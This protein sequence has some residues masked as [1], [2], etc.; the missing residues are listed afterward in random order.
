V[1]G[2]IGFIGIFALAGV[3]ICLRGQRKSNGPQ[4]GAAGPEAPVAPLAATGAMA[5][6]NEQKQP[7]YATPGSDPVQQV[8]M[9]YPP[10]QNG[11]Y[12][13][14][15]SELTGSPPP[16]QPYYNPSPAPGQ[17]IQGQQIPQQQH[18]QAFH[19]P[20]SAQYVELSGQPHYVSEMDS[21]NSATQR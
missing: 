18:Y 7:L 3:F 19:L 15:P 14:T 17:P 20:R 16:N 5:Y 10:M 11:Y 1:I 2:G 21:G 8:S 13:G 9:A 4:N 6:A 12:Q